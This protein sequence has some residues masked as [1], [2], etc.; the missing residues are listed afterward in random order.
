M[1]LGSTEERTKVAV[2]NP[3]TRA[4]VDP[5]VLED[6]GC[7][8][9][10]LCLGNRS[11]E[12]GKMALDDMNTSVFDPGDWRG[13][14][15]YSSQEQEQ[16]Q[17]KQRIHQELEQLKAGLDRLCRPCPW[18]WTF[19][20]E[21]CYFFSTFRQTWMKSVTACQEVGAQLVVIKSDE[22]QSF[23]RRMSKKKGHAWIGL[24]DQKQEGKWVWIDGSP[25]RRSMM[26][27]WSP[28]EPN[29][30]GNEDCANFIDNGWNDSVC[31]AEQFWICKKPASPCSR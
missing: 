13:S 25:L 20:Q 7:G 17:E 28:K 5:W 23:L 3:R 8:S 11:C 26:K 24:S 9:M 27:Y 16:E 1:G 15:V 18:D 21:N 12:V 2:P 10:F 30:D 6:G 19:F 22:E 29:N 14:E 4:F 31:H